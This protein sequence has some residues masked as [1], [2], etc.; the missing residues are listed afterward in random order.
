MFRQ[1]DTVAEHPRNGGYLEKGRQ[2]KRWTGHKIQNYRRRNGE[3]WFPQIPQASGT[4]ATNQPVQLNS[5]SQNLK[6]KPLA[7]NKKNFTPTRKIH[8]SEIHFTL[9]DKT[10]NK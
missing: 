5:D 6:N 1:K 8:P 9:G 2:F 10:T 7:K 3:R 4:V